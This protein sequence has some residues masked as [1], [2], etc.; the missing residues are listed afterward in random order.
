MKGKGW[1]LVGIAAVAAYLERARLQTLFQK[2]VTPQ[3]VTTVPVEPGHQSA[4]V[5]PGNTLVMS[6]PSGASWQ[7]IGGSTIVNDVPTTIGGNVSQTGSALTIQGT[8]G[9]GTVTLNWIDS[10]GSAQQS[11]L[12]VSA[13]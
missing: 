11:T 1:L 7:N 8:Y 10:S 3:L 12:D 2:T 4:A 5:P 9:Q 13:S 6:L